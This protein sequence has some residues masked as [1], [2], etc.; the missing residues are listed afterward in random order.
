MSVL[1]NNLESKNRRSSLGLLH[2]S[3]IRILIELIDIKLHFP[4][5]RAGRIRYSWGVLFWWAS[6]DVERKT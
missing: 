5:T 1:Q 3:Y 2:Y 4:Q 6:P